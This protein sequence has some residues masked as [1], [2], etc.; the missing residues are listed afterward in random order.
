MSVRFIKSASQL[1]ECPQLGLGEVAI[2]GR[3]NAGK[4]SFLNALFARKLAKVS[5]TPG[6]TRLM[7]FF[8]QGDDVVWVDLPGYGFA[9][10]SNREK[11]HWKRMIEDFL[12]NREPLRG[13][14]LVMDIRRKWSADEDLL[15][16]WCS[17]QGLPMA[18]VL[19]KSDKLGFAKQLAAKK[20]IEGKTWPIFVVSSLKKT[21]VLDVGRFVHSEWCSKGAI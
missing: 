5:A 21:G 16:N 12:L 17:S 1:S 10:R 19:N 18:I 13:L 6:K 4:S 7:N 2:V 14:I 9:A 3:S 11:D 8:Q 20:S 15:S